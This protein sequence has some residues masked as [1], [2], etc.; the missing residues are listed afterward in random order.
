[1]LI[2]FFIV[3]DTKVTHLFSHTAIVFLLQLTKCL[4]P[5]CFGVFLHTFMLTG[6]SYCE[7]SSDWE[8]Q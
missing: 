3:V 1:M 5:V 7:M 2:P 4:V 8:Y 6:V